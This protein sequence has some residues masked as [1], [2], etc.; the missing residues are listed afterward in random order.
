MNTNYNHTPGPWQI[1]QNEFCQWIGNENGKAQ[2]AKVFHPA[3][4]KPETAQANARLISSAPEL[5]ALLTD[6]GAWLETHLAKGKINCGT[7][8]RNGDLVSQIRAAIAK[9]TGQK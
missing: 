2:L 9:A 4:M 7:A 1:H 5:L 8:N 3:G 6:V